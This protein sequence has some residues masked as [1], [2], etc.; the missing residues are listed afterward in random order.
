ME[1]NAAVEEPRAQH[2]PETECRLVP[3]GG[4]AVDLEVAGGGHRPLQVPGIV[5]IGLTVPRGDRERRHQSPTAVQVRG[6]LAQVDLH[7]IGLVEP[8][9]RGL[10]ELEL[11]PV[12]IAPGER[13]AGADLLAEGHHRLLGLRTVDTVYGAAVELLVLEGLLEPGH[14]RRV[15]GELPFRGEGRLLLGHG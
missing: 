11:V 2:H 5:V 10:V 6:L 3:T 15:S 14:T 7:P 13:A 9:V 1:G 8:G 4:M 12:R